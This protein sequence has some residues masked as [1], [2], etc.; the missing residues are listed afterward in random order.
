MVR[1]IFIALG[2]ALLLFQFY[3]PEKNL[4]GDTSKAISTKYTIP[5]NVKKTLETACFDCHSNTTRYPWYSNIQPG[6]SFMWGHIKE[7]KKKLNFDTFASRRVAIQNH[8][9][10]EIIEMVEENKMPLFSYTLIHRDAKLNEDQKMEIIN[11]AKSSMDSLR[12][13]YPA[14]SLIIKRK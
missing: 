10:E 2:I 4:S 7:G 3:R 14:D 6:A 5:T 11:W 9:F 12:N 1:K 13:Q 8:K